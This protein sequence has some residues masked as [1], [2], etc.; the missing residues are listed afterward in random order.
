MTDKRTAA[1]IAV[2]RAVNAA[3]KAVA[4]LARAYPIDSDARFVLSVNQVRPSRGKVIGHN[5]DYCMG[6]VRMRV[7]PKMVRDVPFMNI[8]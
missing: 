8:L 2:E 4:A 5:F 7:S 6:Y 1:G 3:K